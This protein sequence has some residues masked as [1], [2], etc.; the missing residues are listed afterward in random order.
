MSDPPPALFP[1]VSATVVVLSPISTLPLASST[2]TVTAG[3][4]ADPAAA[5]VSCWTKASL[6]AG[7]GVMLK[8]DEVAIVKDGLEAYTVEPQA[9]Q[10]NFTWKDDAAQPGKSSYY[11]VRGEQADGQLVWASPMWITFKPGL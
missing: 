11:Y 4:M 9:K 2:A 5:L 3:E 10:V 7:P 1:K 6:V 8:P